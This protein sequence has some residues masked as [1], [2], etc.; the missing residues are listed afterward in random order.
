MNDF[1]GKKVLCVVQNDRVIKG[2]V[3][4]SVFVDSVHYVSITQASKENEEL[5]G[6][7]VKVK[8]EE[9][10]LQEVFDY[11]L[12]IIKHNCWLGDLRVFLNLSRQELDLVAFNLA[13]RLNQKESFDESLNQNYKSVF[14]QTPVKGALVDQLF[15]GL[16]PNVFVPTPIVDI[17]ANTG[18]DSENKN[19]LPYLFLTLYLL[20]DVGSNRGLPE[21]AKPRF[22]LFMSA[23]TIINTQLNNICDIL[24]IKPNP[25]ENAFVRLNE[26]LKKA[27]SVLFS[28]DTLPSAAGPSSS[29]STTV[30]YPEVSSMEECVTQI[31]Q[32]LLYHIPGKHRALAKAHLDNI[33][34]AARQKNATPLLFAYQKHFGLNSVFESPFT[35]KGIPQ[36]NLYERTLNPDLRTLAVKEVSRIID[37]FIPVSRGE[38][39]YA[40]NVNSF[41]HHNMLSFLLICCWSVPQNFKD[42]KS[43][44]SV[45]HHPSLVLED[46]IPTLRHVDRQNQIYRRLYHN[47]AAVATQ[48]Q[49]H[50]TL[51]AYCLQQERLSSYFIVEHLAH[52]LGPVLGHLIHEILPDHIIDDMILK[53][54]RC[55]PDQFIS[56]DWWEE[57]PFF[58]DRTY[59]RPSVFYQRFLYNRRFY[60]I[61]FK[62]GVILKGVE[63]IECG[64]QMQDF[65]G[66]LEK[67]LS[68]DSVIKYV[69]VPISTLRSG[70][71]SPFD[72]LEMPRISR[73]TS[74]P[75]VSNMELVSPNNRK[76]NYKKDSRL[77][78][79][80]DKVPGGLQPSSMYELL[81]RMWRIEETT[82]HDQLA[83]YVADAPTNPKIAFWLFRCTGKAL[84]N[85]EPLM[86]F[87][88]AI[89]PTLVPY[90]MLSLMT[91][92]AWKNL[93][94]IW[95][96]EVRDYLPPFQF[97]VMANR[98]VPGKPYFENKDA[99]FNLT[100]YIYEDFNNTTL[101]T[102]ECVKRVNELMGVTD[103][104]EQHTRCLL[105]LLNEESGSSITQEDIDYMKKQIILH[106]NS[107]VNTFTL[108][109]EK[110]IFYRLYK[111]HAVASNTSPAIPSFIGYPF[112]FVHA[113]KKHANR[114][115]AWNPVV[116]FT[117]TV[118][119]FGPHT[120]ILS[121]LDMTLDKMA[122]RGL[123]LPQTI[124][125]YP[126]LLDQ[127]LSLEKENTLD[128][129]RSHPFVVNLHDIHLLVWQ[130]YHPSP[131]KLLSER[132]KQVI[133]NYLKNFYMVYNIPS[134]D[135]F[136]QTIPQYI[137]TP[138]NAYIQFTEDG[139]YI[140]GD[141]EW[142]SKRNPIQRA[143]GSYPPTLLQG[144]TPSSELNVEYRFDNTHLSWTILSTSPL[145]VGVLVGH[146]QAIKMYF[147]NY[148][149]GWT[150]RTDTLYYVKEHVWFQ[151]VKSSTED[152]IGKSGTYDLVEGYEIDA[153]VYGNAIKHV[154]YTEIDTEA[155][156]S[157]SPIPDSF[158]VDHPGLRYWALR[159]ISDHPIT[160]FKTDSP[161]RFQKPI[162]KDIYPLPFLN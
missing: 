45:V 57:D 21:W 16:Y 9:L 48:A 124:F 20:C 63:I 87:Y 7:V 40:F 12:S 54:M 46:S 130:H 109:S 153:R 152:F 144:Y 65:G 86:G 77:I 71:A 83:I 151:F 136:T 32:M 42:S 67:Y 4:S 60:V 1:F 76:S 119:R 90:P 143:Q 134:S 157:F 82:P 17:Q 69:F 103:K 108:A 27:R 36:I 58:G 113:L 142:I 53:W 19:S 39:N 141:L 30:S 6:L 74:T 111:L 97:W 139:R 25:N 145:N 125:N 115:F 47:N 84:K 56:I 50:A 81:K 5:V 155:N 61:G 73:L 150:W 96:G 31:H 147:H 159:V 154:R 88:L 22:G 8:D 38:V 89:H 131:S 62:H 15:D 93:G 26:L 10:I 121:D 158:V 120:V 118:V 29:T 106:Q 100:K 70:I 162:M 80:S 138:S 13:K 91:Y 52:A 75:V 137:S 105:Y 41:I 140:T 123:P 44:S 149:A 11:V 66:F 43:Q 107:S 24:P 2:I 79:L 126:E 23:L 117:E 129:P 33:K 161:F 135:Q 102:R 55:N 160:I 49:Q 94:P 146:V 110:M 99:Y 85:I 112:L 28:P 37:C 64:D 101:S 132:T 122:S 34:T 14:K 148:P 78:D 114:I 3:Q 59:S 98:F 95:Y 127:D 116:A 18:D 72:N 133:A 128:V 156:A 68:E 92:E 35:I 51:R 104:T